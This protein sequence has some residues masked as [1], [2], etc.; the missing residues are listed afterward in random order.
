M[1]STNIFARNV[2]HSELSA[3]LDENG[4]SIDLFGE[5]VPSNEFSTN[6]GQGRRGS[7][8]HLLTLA[9]LKIRGFDSAELD[10]MDTD[11]ISDIFGTMRRFQVKA[12]QNST[13]FGPGG[14]TGYNG[15]RALSSYKGKIDAFAFVLLARRLVYYVSVNAVISRSINIK[16]FSHQACDLSFSELLRRWK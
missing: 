15:H 2:T 5:L 9:D 4:V 1:T 10:G 11:I 14:Y 6:S 12:S 16:T 3:E 13:H 7:A 8:G